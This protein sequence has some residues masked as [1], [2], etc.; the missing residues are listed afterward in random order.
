MSDFPVG[1]TVGFVTATGFF[2]RIIEYRS[3]GGPSHATTLVKDGTVIDARLFG[4]IKERPVSYLSGEKV[5]WYRIPATQ[6]KVANAIQF[7]KSQCGQAYSWTD[8]LAFLVPAIF[9]PYTRAKHPWMCSWLQA[10]CLME[11][12]II[13]KIDRP[14][15]TLTPN[16]NLIAVTAFGAIKLPGPVF[17]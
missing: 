14:A 6:E 15:E 4:G 9:R 13:G 3:A 10:S 5:D 7:L 16:D 17:S 12:G 8:I 1:L 11:A 2:S